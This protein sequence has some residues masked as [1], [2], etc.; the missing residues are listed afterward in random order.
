VIILKKG[1]VL[2]KTV[3]D[4]ESNEL[5]P[6]WSE[7]RFCC[8]AWRG[9]N[10]TIMSSISARLH[11]WQ[12]TLGHAGRAHLSLSLRVPANTH[13]NNKMAKGSRALSFAAH[14][15]WEH[16]AKKLHARSYSSPSAHLGA[17]WGIHKTW[18]ALLCAAANYTTLCSAGLSSSN[19]LV[20]AG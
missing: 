17:I 10:K 8:V 12:I 3:E 1:L 6:H 2:Q 13:K 9:N 7:R 18:N 5:R 20:G 16:T 14:Q 19:C 15:T 4:F 11:C